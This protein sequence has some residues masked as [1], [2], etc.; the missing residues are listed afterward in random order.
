MLVHLLEMLLSE[1]HNENDKERLRLKLHEMESL[2]YERMLDGTPL[3]P[4]ERNSFS[5]VL[6]EMEEL[7]IHKLNYPDWRKF[8]RQ[9][10]PVFKDTGG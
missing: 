2:I 1:A 7:R 9:K 3:M 5:V 8:V 10:P 4:A 6:G